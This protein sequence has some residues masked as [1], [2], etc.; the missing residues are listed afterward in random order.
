VTTAANGKQA[1]RLLLGEEQSAGT[2]VEDQ[3]QNFTPDGRELPREWISAN[4][5]NKEGRF[6]ITFLDNQMPVMS[7]VEMVK[8][9]RNLGREDLIVGVTGNALLQDQEEYVEAGADQCVC[10]T[11]DRWKFSHLLLS[12][13]LD[14]TRPGRKS[15]G[16]AFDS[17]RTPKN[18]GKRFRSLPF[19]A[20]T[21]A[22]Q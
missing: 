6:A 11:V 18:T 14:E 3:E 17:R 13:R 22:I 20:P 2:P 16:D 5:V 10:I 8:K 4:T 19:P 15:A 21:A 9:L 1:L 7:G 12:Q